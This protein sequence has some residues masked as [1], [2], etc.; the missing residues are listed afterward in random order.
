[1][2]SCPTITL[3]REKLSIYAKIEERFSSSVHILEQRLDDI[4]YW[5]GELEQKL[6][7][8]KVELDALIAFR[9]RVAQA[10]ESTADPLHIAQQCLANR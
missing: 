6:D 8:L 3:I 1:M 7:N 5:K 10:L 4:K 2:R 9:N